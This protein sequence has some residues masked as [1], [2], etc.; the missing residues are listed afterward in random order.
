MEELQR[1]CYIR[2]YRVYNTKWE[3]ATGEDWHVIILEIMY[4]L[5]IVVEIFLVENILCV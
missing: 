4:A 1:P 3:A 5:I 2:G